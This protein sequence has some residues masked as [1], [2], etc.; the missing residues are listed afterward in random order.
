MLLLDM[1]TC[2][3]FQDDDDATQVGDELDEWMQVVTIILN[4]C[5][6]PQIVWVF[7]GS[8]GHEEVYS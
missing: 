7:L 4:K 5:Y 1:C 8:C 2:C 6:W 3:V